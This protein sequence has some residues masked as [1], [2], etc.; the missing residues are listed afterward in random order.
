MQD[1]GIWVR[2]WPSTVRWSEAV[3][4]PA[5]PGRSSMARHS[6]VLAHHAARG[7]NPNVFLKVGA[8]FSLWEEAVMMV[9][10]MSTTIQPVSAFPAI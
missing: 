7:W 6:M 10:S 5:L 9:A 1:P 3:L 8:A 4:D 2:A